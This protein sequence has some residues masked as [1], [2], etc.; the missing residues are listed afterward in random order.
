VQ[1]LARV[2]RPSGRL[3]ISNPHPLATGLLGWRATVRDDG[4]R[5][6]V[7]PEY[8]HSHS[9]YIETFAAAGLQVR[10]CIEPVLSAEQA[11]AEAK[12]GFTEAFRAALTGFPVVIVWDLIGTGG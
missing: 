11:A 10:R 6:I 3:I 7:I 2:L 8:P 1:E 4:G 5:T 12:A 9:A